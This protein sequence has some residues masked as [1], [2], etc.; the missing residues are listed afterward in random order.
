M[1]LF[2]SVYLEYLSYFRKSYWK[3]NE[4]FTGVDHP[5]HHPQWFLQI[6]GTSRDKLSAGTYLWVHVSVPNEGLDVWLYLLFP[7]KVVFKGFL[8]VSD[9]LVSQHYPYII[10]PKS[11]HTH[12]FLMAMWNLT[13]FCFGTHF[14]WDVFSPFYPSQQLS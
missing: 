12:I 3:S 1:I 7:M 11:K 13:P 10:A 8:Q 9:Q 4:P 14:I 6:S 2:L 5:T